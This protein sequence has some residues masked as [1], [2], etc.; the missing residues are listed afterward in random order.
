M[1]NM[2]TNYDNDIKKYVPCFAPPAPESPK[3][4]KLVTNV[5]GQVLGVQVEQSHPLQLYFHLE[6]VC[7]IEID[8]IKP[9][10]VLFE[11]LTTTHKTIVTKEFAA[12]EILDPFTGDLYIY[13]SQDELK[14]LKKETYN[15]RLTIKMAEL[16]LVVFAEKDGYLIVR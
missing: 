13:L 5:K 11:I 6:N 7:D 3:G 1:V 8:E 12:E 4:P 14:D 2:F 15:M 10:S 16:D 9:G